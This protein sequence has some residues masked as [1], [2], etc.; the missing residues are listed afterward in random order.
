MDISDFL[1]LLGGVALFLFGMSLM[2]DGLKKVAGNKM[3]LVLYRLSGTPLRALLLGTA[4]TALIQSSSA[5]SV[6]VVGFVNSGMMKLVQAISVIEGALIGTSVTGWIVALSSIEGAG[7]VSILSTSNLSA[8]VALSGILLRMFS[9]RQLHRHVGDILLGFAVLMFGM[10]AMSGA[11][12]PLRES[13]MFLSM[14]TSV[15]HP[16]VGILAGAIFTAVLQ[17]ASASVGILQALSLTGAV[18]FRVAFP[19]LLGIAIGSALPVLLSAL[20]AKTDGRRAAWSYLVLELFSAILFGSVYYAIE[21]VG[22][23]GIEDKVLDPFSIAAINSGF[24]IVSK[25]MLLPFNPLLVK[26]LHAVIH[27]SEAEKTAN[28]AFDR[29]DERF[30]SHPPLAVEQSRLTA[31]DMAVLTKKNFY[32]A[33]DLLDKYS[34]DGFEKV[35]ADE[36]RVDL[37]ED[38]LGTYLMRLNTHELSH[39]QN[40]TASKILHT[41]SDFER[42]S[43]HALNTAEAA[44]EIH[45]KKIRFSD[46]ADAELKILKCAIREIVELSFACFISNDLNTAYK[47]EPL[48][49]RIDELCDEMKLHHVERLQEGTCSLSQGFVFNDLL[50]NLERVADHCSNL[51]IAVIELHSNSY[52]AHEYVIRLK[53]LRAHH[54]DEYYEQYEKKYTV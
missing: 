2:G 25:G 26:F 50:T 14:L 36:D 19:L 43:D 49:Q 13:R 29:L 22:T 33:L 17:S 54:F 4:V 28:A 40:E 48:E 39:S 5:T 34:E 37:F 45:E 1:T 8:I 15:S 3:E 52:D 31:D 10:H 35:K 16:L 44:Q 6:M 21:A 53:E 9:K 27:P 30:L 23:L 11:V 32:D 12:E 24:R 42:I 41:L 20:G 38:K 46:A 18:S 47:V 7:W 51:A